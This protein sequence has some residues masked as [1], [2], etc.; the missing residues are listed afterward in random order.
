MIIFII[1]SRTFINADCDF[2]QWFVPSNR[3]LT[4]TNCVFEDIFWF[5]IVYKTI[6][7]FNDLTFIS[8]D[9]SKFSKL[10]ETGHFT[11][12][13]GG[14]EQGYVYSRQLLS[15]EQTSDYFKTWK[16][17]FCILKCSYLSWRHKFLL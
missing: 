12:W 13:W 4:T 10:W 6:I 16:S 15:T 2:C 11:F 14:W 7:T 5:Y 17:V 3:Q 9:N 8:K 1:H